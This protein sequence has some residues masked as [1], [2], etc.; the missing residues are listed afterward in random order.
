M[1]L[2]ECGKDLHLLYNLKMFFF[3]FFMMFEFIFIL[4]HVYLFWI[5]I[6]FVVGTLIW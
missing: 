5:L 6:L 2:D 1:I 4:N 3:F